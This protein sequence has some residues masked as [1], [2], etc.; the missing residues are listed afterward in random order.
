MAGLTFFKTEHLELI[1]TFYL[2]IGMEMWLDQDDCVILQHGNL[3]L[4]FCSREG[5]DT[6]GLI[7]LFYPERQDV[8]KLFKQ[9]KASAIEAPRYNEKYRIYH[10]FA[11]DPEGRTLEIQM[12]DHP[13]EPYLRGDELLVQR[14]SV[15]TFQDRQIPEH[16]L[17]GVFEL[18]RYAPTSRNCQSY[19]YIRIHDRS[20]REFFAGLRGGSSAPIARAPLAV[21]VCVDTSLTR[22]SYQ[23]GSIAAYHL[24]LAAK[25]Y[26]LGTCWIAAMDRDE[27]KGRLGIP[28][29]HY[30]AT[31]TPLGYPEETPHMPL[32][33]EVTDMVRT[34]G[35]M[36][37][38]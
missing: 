22:R 10:F 19:Y 21:A 18:C 27:V 1:K 6:Q 24:L 26:G 9:L 31:I 11:R 4:G 35:K 38:T 5:V 16:T 34:L 33:R 25:L 28:L 13:L 30:V 36:E 17:E 29:E 12:F 2:G 15:R 32:R 14:R 7:T 37:W 20:A 3:L 23:D 8:D